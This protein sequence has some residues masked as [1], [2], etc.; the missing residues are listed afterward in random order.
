MFYSKTYPTDKDFFYIQFFLNVSLLRILNKCFSVTHTWFH[1]FLSAVLLVVWMCESS[2]VVGRSQHPGACASSSERWRLSE[3]SCYPLS[4]AAR[5]AGPSI[6]SP[7]LVFKREEPLWYSS[8]LA[9]RA[10]ELQRL[11]G[12]LFPV[13]SGC[14]R[15][16]YCFLSHR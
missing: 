2:G 14:S 12:V 16:G 11:V 1:A 3:V 15:P 9:P 8:G 10:A 5:M 7:W 13:C 4:S 6:A